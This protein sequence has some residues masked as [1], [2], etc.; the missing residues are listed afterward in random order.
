MS[1][2][3]TKRELKAKETR[4]RILRTAYRL[5]QQYGPE[6]VSIRDIASEAQLTTGALYHYFSSKDEL[7]QIII[8]ERKGNMEKLAAQ[9]QNRGTCLESLLYFLSELLHTQIEADGKIMSPYRLRNRRYV[10]GSDSGRP[11]FYPQGKAIENFIINAQAAGELD[12]RWSSNEIV[13]N[14]LPELWNIHYDYSVAE[15]DFDLDQALLARVPLILRAY[16]PGTYDMKDWWK[17][18]VSDGTGL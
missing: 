2:H 3:M 16:A 4:E 18:T 15:S 1:I 6:R 5:F 14:L 7:L 13:R 9:A 8:Q 12:P 17:S 11:S 10:S